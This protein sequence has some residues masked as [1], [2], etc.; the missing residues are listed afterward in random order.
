[1]LRSDPRLQVKQYFEREFAGDNLRVSKV[2]RPS[3]SNYAQLSHSSSGVIFLCQ[4][5][6]NQQKI[7]RLSGISLIEVLITI[8]IVGILVGMAVPSFQSMIERGRVKALTET[9]YSNLQ[10]AK[11][12]ALKGSQNSE[13]DVLVIFRHDTNPQCFGM[14]R[15]TNDCDCANDDSTAS[16]FC[17]IDG[18]ER[19]VW[20]DSTTFPGAQLIGSGDLKLVFDSIHGTMNANGTI[21]A[22]STLSGSGRLKIVVSRLGRI[23]ICAVNDDI[24][25]YP[26]CN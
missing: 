26:G 1:M 16:D 8:V 2:N 12:E 7:T 17:E 15:G 24:P 5:L 19:R 23:R 21:I 3:S 22:G 11:S 13:K 6:L 9:I 4:S 18:A 14:A 10:Y 25:G 20:V